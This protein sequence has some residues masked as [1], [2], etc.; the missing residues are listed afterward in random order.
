[1]SMV[2]ANSSAQDTEIVSPPTDSISA[3]SFSPTADILGVTSWDNAVRLYETNA[4]G[5]S[6]QKAEY[7][8]EGPVFDMCWLPDGSKCISVGADKAGRM[9]D[10]ASGS[11]SQIAAHDAPIKACR[12]VPQANGSGFLVTAGWDKVLKYWD[13]RT[14]NPVATVALPAKAYTLDVQN[15]LMVVGCGDKTIQIFDLN[16]PGVIF[17]GQDS[18]LKHQT[19]V[20]GCFPSAKGFAVGSVEGRVAIQHMEKESLAKNFSF[21]CHR[22]PDAPKA[23][24]QVAVYGVNAMA[25]EKAKGYG[26]FATGGADGRIS[27]WDHDNRS[28]LK[29]LDAF[30]PVSPSAPMT[31]I[32][33]L[34]FNHNSTFL[35]A[36]VSY[37]WSKGHAGN[38]PGLG[39]RVRLH[40]VKLEEIAPKP[41]TR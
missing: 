2:L 31:P 12:W 14:S 32:V 4:Q 10:L 25:F 6:Q 18:P 20:V 1:M 7:K 8:H 3:V 29:T 30:P 17:K 38:V 13:L 15:P 36:G 9:Y 40:P 24:E 19:R 23:G 37:D 35:A 26:T 28:K 41:K 11:S 33:S 39:T 21:K 5:Q 22:L 16:N 27:F 34:S